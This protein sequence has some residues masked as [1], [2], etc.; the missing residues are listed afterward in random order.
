MSEVITAAVAA[1]TEKMGDD[2]LEGSA[3]FIIGDEGSVVIDG[4][5]VR[6]CDIETDVS[7]TADVGTFQEILEGTL[8]PTS[9]FMAGRLSVDG[10]MTLAMKLG[11][12]L[13]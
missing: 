12:L 9:A 7:L 13:T 2:R 1:L 6:A 4:I 10:D 3:K 8:D 11:G 5:G